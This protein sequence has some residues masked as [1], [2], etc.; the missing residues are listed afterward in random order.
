MAVLSNNMRFKLCFFSFYIS[1]I[2]SM[3]NIK[4]LIL[5]SKEKAAKR[6]IAIMAVIKKVNYSASKGFA[7]LRISDQTAHVDSV[8]PSTSNLTL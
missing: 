3:L 8:L 4:I 1:L 5:K 6:V 2:H 7:E